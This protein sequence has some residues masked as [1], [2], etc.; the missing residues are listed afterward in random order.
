MD[1]NF[2]ENNT[3]DLITTDMDYKSRSFKRKKR[4]AAGFFEKIGS[5][6]ANWWKNLKK[7][8]KITLCVVTS[9]VLVVAIVASVFLSTFNYNYNEITVKPNELGFENVIDQKIV[10]V[11]LFGIDTR[12][13]KSFQGNSDSMMILSINTEAKTVKIVSV[14][15]DSLVPIQLENRTVYRKLNSAYASGGPELAIKTINQNFG[16]DISE[17]ATVNFFGMA[18]IIDAVGGIDAELTRQ[19]VAAQ[20]IDG[21]NGLVKRHCKTIGVDPEPY[22]I[23][24]PG[25]HHLNGVQAVAYSRIRKYVNIW[26]TNNDFGR[27][28]RQ[29]YVMEQLFN[30]AL[31]LEKSK[32]VKL[33]K[34]LIPYTETSFSYSEIM[35]LAFDVLLHSPTF[36]QTR[37]PLNE[38]QMRSPNVPGVG[39]VVY[40]DLDFAKN[41]LHAFFYENISPEDYVE[42][43]GIGKNDWYGQIVGVPS[44][45]QKPNE[46]NNTSNVTSS[47]QSKP[48]TSDTSSVESTVSSTPTPSQ[49][50][51][52]SSEDATSS[53]GTT[54]TESQPTT[55]SD[56]A[57]SSSTPTDSSV[58]TP[59]STPATPETPPTSSAQGT[60]SENA[61]QG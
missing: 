23:T 50:E 49:N 44:G 41:L 13:K 48:T 58:Q 11:A 12:S 18:E 19:E 38:Y 57:N 51:V 10:N 25:K 60:T 53:E 30:K 52:T 34:A 40:Y 14:M 9:I 28:D 7:W 17:Y 31:T 15:R 46:N 29:R 55:S 27:T 24:T 3:G 26:G 21:F 20:H 43:N 59:S 39:S 8:K 6:I 33:V 37:M 36:E 35:G 22:Y 47:T 45:S 1:K 42:A 56:V 4:G 54:S 2:N 16:L 32:Y 61:S 5:S